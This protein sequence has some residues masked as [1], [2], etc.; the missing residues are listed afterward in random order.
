MSD[1]SIDLLRTID[2]IAGDL[3]SRE[4]LEAAENAVWPQAIWDALV[5][6]GLTRGILPETQDGAGL[7]LSEGLV[8][9]KRVA[10]H[11]LPVPFAET[12][13]A[14]WLLSQNGLNVPDEPITIM[15]GSHADDFGLIRVGTDLRLAGKACDVPW[16]E[17]C[18]YA[19][20]SSQLDDSSVI[21]LVRLADNTEYT[22]VR[23]LADEPKT[24]I[25]MQDAEV[26]AYAAR[27]DAADLL[28]QYGALFR[29]V[30]MV[31]ALDRILEQSITYANE[32]VTFGRPIAKFQAVQHMLAAMAG[33]VAAANAATTIALA[34]GANT[35]N[36][37]AIAVAKSRTGEAA[38]KA[39]EIAHQIHG[40]M[41]FTKEHSLHNS[42]RRLWSWRDDFGSERYWN[43]ILGKAVT[44]GGAHSLWPLLAQGLAGE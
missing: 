11:C 19:V 21:G 24:T 2:R 3:C 6:N 5:A 4:V 22:H 38:G 7:T 27:P 35:S 23:N 31:G 12:L 37:L 30:Q 33:E 34:H 8:M 25:N 17:N 29:S 42:T 40:A 26:V 20:F 16:A 36:P 44:K 39:C 28:M 41:G 32:R 13:L 18:R 1:E 15:P 10:Y 43:E 14:S 9:V